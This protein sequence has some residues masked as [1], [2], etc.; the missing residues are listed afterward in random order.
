MHKIY[1]KL[2]N[3]FMLLSYLIIDFRQ[4]F[5]EATMKCDKISKKV[6][7]RTFLKLLNVRQIW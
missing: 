3:G 1:L 4:H 7:C 6:R 5:T 2:S